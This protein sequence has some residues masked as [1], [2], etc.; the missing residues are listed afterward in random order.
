MNSI[1]EQKERVKFD[2]WFFHHAPE[3]A[4]KDTLWAAWLGR[5]L[6]ARKGQNDPTLDKR[7]RVT[8]DNRPPVV[9]MAKSPKDAMAKADRQYP[10]HVAI[11]AR[12]PRYANM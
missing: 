1:F 11:D 5:A 4:D 3:G 7:Y 8:F 2:R 9:I 12:R 6:L 10:E